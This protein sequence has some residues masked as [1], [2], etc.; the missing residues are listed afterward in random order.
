MKFCG[1]SW[2]PAHFNDGTLGLGAQGTTHAENE[3]STSAW[4]SNS[5]QSRTVRDKLPGCPGGQRAAQVLPRLYLT[6]LQGAVCPHPRT[7]AGSI[8]VW[9]SCGEE[10]D[11]SGGFRDGNTQ[12]D[13]TLVRYLLT[14]SSLAIGFVTVDVLDIQI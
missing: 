9:V 2:A 12:R 14:G 6:L 11:P 3:S 4:E 8:T 13:V 1:Q 10:E 5:G 7:P